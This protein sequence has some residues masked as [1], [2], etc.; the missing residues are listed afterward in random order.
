MSLIPITSMSLAVIPAMT[1]TGCSKNDNR[2]QII[3]DTDVGNDCDDIGAL[4]ILGNAYKKNMV[5]IK[6]VTVCNRKLSTFHTTDIMLEQY[7]IDCPMGWSD[8]EQ[9][10]PFGD[11]YARYVDD[12]YTARSERVSKKIPSATKVLRKALANAKGKKIKLITLGMLN[13][14]DNLLK[15]GP[16]KI[17]KKTGKELFEE[18]VSEMVLMGGRFDDQTYSEFNILQAKEAAVNVINNTSVPK[19]F[20]GWEVGEPV[21]TGATFYKSSGSPQ[22]LAYDKYN[23]GNLRESWDPL[24]MYV[25]LIDCWKYSQP[26][27]AEVQL[28]GDDAYTKFTPSPTGNCQYVLPHEDPQAIANELETWMTVYQ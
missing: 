19:T 18:N 17:S 1:L 2:V 4:S 6:A 28:V 27:T 20:V 16:D 22:R 26:G 15:S 5:D 25:A 13:N 3:V 21:K 7:G 24:T 14:I 11:G 8:N 23:D 9:P 12:A 10:L